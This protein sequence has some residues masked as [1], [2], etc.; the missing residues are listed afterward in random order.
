MKG[1]FFATGALGLGRANT[2]GVSRGLA[3]GGVRVNH[4]V[5]VVV[6]LVVKYLMYDVRFKGRSRRS[7]NDKM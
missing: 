1:V 2:A 3:A 7:I 4:F 5:V 6:V